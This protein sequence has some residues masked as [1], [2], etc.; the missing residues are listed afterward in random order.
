MLYTKLQPNISNGSAGKVYFSGLAILATVAIFDS[1][2]ITLMPCSLVMLHAKFENHGCSGFR[3]CHLNGLKC[4][5]W[6]KFSNG[7]C[8][9]I[10]L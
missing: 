5:G 8:E 10:L 2:P 4:Q 7:H 3:E 1:Q 6:R 9:L